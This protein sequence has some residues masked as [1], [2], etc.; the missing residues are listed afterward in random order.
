MSRDQ[1]VRA[2]LAVLEGDGIAGLSIRGVARV[3]GV[4]TGAVYRHVTDA[5]GLVNLVLSEAE[6]R[7]EIQAGII[8]E[9]TCVEAAVAVWA[10][11]V[12][13][14]ARASAAT[15]DV[16]LHRR[17]LPAD[18]LGPAVLDRMVQLARSEGLP[19][20]GLARALS[21]ASAVA[22]GFAASE[23]LI[24]QELREDWLSATRESLGRAGHQ[25]AVS[26]VAALPQ[27]RTGSRR[28]V[29]EAIARAIVSAAVESHRRAGGP[30]DSAPPLPIPAGPA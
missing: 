21:D 29:V 20:E 7:V 22:L 5:H 27:M 10:G 19:V 26:L 6:A 23:R 16:M 28:D 2:A 24:R 17:Y 12:Y 13:E 4:T 3:L 25:D 18:G 15:L 1:V 8:H 30:G 14:E 11:T 9:L